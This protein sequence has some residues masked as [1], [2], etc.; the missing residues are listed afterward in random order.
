MAA[1]PECKEE[2]ILVG[3]EYVCRNGCLGGG[4]VIEPVQVIDQWNLPSGFKAMSEVGE[5]GGTFPIRI[6]EQGVDYL[7]QPVAHELFLGLRHGDWVSHS[8]RFYK[9]RFT[10]AIKPRTKKAAAIVGL[11]TLAIGGFIL[12]GILG[13]APPAG[14]QSHMAIRPVLQV[15]VGST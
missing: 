8:A 6:K 7:D 1:C 3:G 2:G 9:R 4:L 13:Q 10:N 5:L 15:V 14:L 11:A 12:V